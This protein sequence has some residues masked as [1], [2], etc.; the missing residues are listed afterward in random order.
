MLFVGETRVR[1]GTA[2]LTERQKV[3]LRMIVQTLVTKVKSNNALQSR[4]VNLLCWST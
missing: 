4:S 2:L 1:E 3:A